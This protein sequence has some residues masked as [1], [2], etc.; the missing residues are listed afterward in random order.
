MMADF[1]AEVFQNDYLPAGGTDVHAVVAVTAT[2]AGL[3][4]T[5]GDAAEMV[6]VDCSGSMGWT[7][8]ETGRKI[9]AASRAARA[10]IDELVDGTWFGVVAGTHEA[11][12]V[13]PASR[14]PQLLVQARPETKAA[15]KVALHRLAADGGTAIGSWLR[16]ATDAFRSVPAA[17][18]HAI[19]LTDGRN[20]HEERDALVAA[21]EGAKGILQCDCRGVG[22][23]WIVDELRMIS[24]ELMGTVDL[25][26]KPADLKADFERMTRESMGRGVPDVRLRVWAPQGAEVL[27]VR[28]V[29]PQI[30]DVS[31]RRGMVTPLVSEYPTGAW[32]DERRDY[33]LAVRVRPQPVGSERLAAR[34]QV[35]VGGDTVAQGLIKT[36]W[37]HDDTLSAPIHPAVAHYTGQAEL[38]QAIQAG[39]QAKAEGHMEEATNLLGRAVQLA[40]STGNDETAA[41]LSRVVD[42]F[43]ADL[44]T[45]RLKRGAT[46][47][48]EMALDTHSTKTT[49]VR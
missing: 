48:D 44:G 23:D 25:V 13:Y 28:Q 27:F 26:A 40:T 32:G 8:D 24:H 20:E 36:F 22:T 3:A 17:Q 1:S 2:G 7:D 37:T 4:G 31:R 38:A 47:L 14:G 5:A 34:V 11:R 30:D 6:I 15:A 41:M 46:R 10:A 33:H 35:L 19:L 42:V 9:T 12:L 49:R 39:L 21:V 45:V 29:G 18:C 16:L 43:D